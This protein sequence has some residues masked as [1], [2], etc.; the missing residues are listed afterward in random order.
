M[1]GLLR[2][3]S[4]PGIGANKIRALIGRFKSPE[5]IFAAKSFELVNVEGIDQILA[6]RI[7]QNQHDDFVKIQL[8]RLEK[9]NSRIIT[10]WDSEYPDN[11]K[12]IY[13]PPAFLFLKG[14]FSKSDSHSIAI[15]GSRSPTNYG[16]MVAE[17]FGKELAARGISIVSGLAR[18][19]DTIA[20]WSALRGGGR[21]IAVLGSGV[22]VIYPP[23]NKKLADAISGNGVLLSEFPMGAKPDASNFPRRNRIISALSM[24]VVVAEAGV[25]S[26][27]LITANIALEQ[28]REV[29]A[30]PGNINSSKSIGCNNLIAD[31]AKL[32]QSI[33]DIINELKPQL[34]RLLSEARN[35]TPAINLTE[36]E[37]KIYTSL[38]NEPIHIDQLAEQNQMSTSQVLGILLA[39]ELKD[40][41]RQI[42]GKFFIKI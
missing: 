24:G 37:Q 26:G 36:I 23:E 3:Y 19:I 33:E 1:E 12:R 16:K 5:R 31:G 41:V 32:V 39:L 13:D 20:H 7:V 25:K 28:N 2:L 9:A 21:T 22:D 4:I 10:F 11:L 18:G 8:S 42:P 38:S 14:E 15:V 29:F 27:A 17:K 40:I 30:V 35:E 6:Q 34:P